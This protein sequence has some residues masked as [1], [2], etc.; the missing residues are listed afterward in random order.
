MIMVSWSDTVGETWSQE[1]IIAGKKINDSLS[2]ISTSVQP[3]ETEW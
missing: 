1:T 2:D 3:H